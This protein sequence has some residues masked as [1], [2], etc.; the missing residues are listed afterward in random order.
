MG[1][2]QQLLVFEIAQRRFALTLL[3][4]VEVHRAVTI[5]P[6]PSSMEAVEGL[7]NVRGELIPVYDLRARFGF[8]PKTLCPEDYLIIAA[9]GG[10]QVAL[11]ADRVSDLI[12][13]DQDLIDEG[14]T[15]PHVEGVAKLEDGLAMIQDLASF[16]SLAER[17][18]LRAILGG[19]PP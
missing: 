10:V 9:V 14:R 18:E 2:P 17:A 1:A 8:A 15:I 6:L 3:R 5:V 13:V 7:I 16:L 11:R 4:V 19:E 12:T